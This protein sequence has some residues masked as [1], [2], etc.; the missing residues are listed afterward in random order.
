[1][2]SVDVK[3]KVDL[4]GLRAQEEQ[5]DGGRCRLGLIGLA[6][7]GWHRKPGMTAGTIFGH[8]TCSSAELIPLRVGTGT[9]CCAIYC[10]LD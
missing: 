9:T 5:Q 7:A 1:M 8:F 6:L 10:G 2:V 3:P 4:E